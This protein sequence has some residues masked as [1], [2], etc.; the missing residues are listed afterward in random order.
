MCDGGEGALPT[1]SPS[2]S[3]LLPPGD[4]RLERGPVFLDGSELVE[5]QT[6]PPQHL[7]RLRGWPPTPCHQPRAIV[8]RAEAHAAIRVELYSLKGS[9]AV[10]VQVL[11]PFEGD[12]PLGAAARRYQVAVNGQPAGPIGP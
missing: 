2:P 1:P 9:G 11:M 8:S 5:L 6:Y 7:L 12:V 3:D 10:Y 4:E